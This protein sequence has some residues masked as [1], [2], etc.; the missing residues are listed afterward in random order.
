[1]TRLTLTAAALAAALIALT[2]LPARGQPPAG[3]EPV[4]HALLVGVTKY[5]NLAPRLQLEGPVNDVEMMRKMLAEQ[6]KV[7]AG[8]ITVLSEATGAPNAG[9]EKLLP[10]RANI[11][12]EF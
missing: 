1:M 8:N 4:R 11:E 10:N 7:L 5:P 12:R 3:K 9:G 2:T 6:F